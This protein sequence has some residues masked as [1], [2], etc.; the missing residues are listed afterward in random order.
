M[1]WVSERATS[2]L[3]LLMPSRL[4]QLY[5]RTDRSRSSIGIDSSLE[6]TASTGAGPISMP[7]AAVFSSRARPNSSVRVRPADAM[8]SRGRDRRLGLDVNDEAVEVGALTGTSCLDAVGHLEHGRVDRVDRNLAG[9]GVLVAVLGGRHVAAATLDGEFELE[10]GLV[11]E[12]RDDELGVVDL[13]TGR[14]RDVGGG[15]LAGTLLAQVRGDGL[16]VLARDDEVLDVQDDLGDIFLDTGNGAELV[17]HAVDADAGDSSAGDRGEQGAAQRV[18]E[19]VTE[20]GL[21]RLDDEPRAE[22]ARC[23]LR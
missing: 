1:S 19:G 17:Q 2:S 22:L 14:S 9:L 23:S 20:A 7:S 21:E 13:D 5:E 11:V 12:R 6:R 18:A 8:A 10:L 3:T 4:R 16:V 15:D